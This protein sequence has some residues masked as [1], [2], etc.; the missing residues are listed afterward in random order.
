MQEKDGCMKFTRQITVF[1]AADLKTESAFWAG[2]LGG[3]VDAGWAPGDS[4]STAG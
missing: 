3:T 1:D 2:M 4:L